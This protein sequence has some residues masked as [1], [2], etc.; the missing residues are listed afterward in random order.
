MITGVCMLSL[1][2]VAVQRQTNTSVG[3]AFKPGL[4]MPSETASLRELLN[5]N[6]TFAGANYS[7]LT[8]FED[9]EVPKKHWL[10]E[11]LAQ[12]ASADLSQLQAVTLIKYED[13]FHAIPHWHGEQTTVVVY[14]SSVN[15][16]GHVQTIFP[17]LGLAVTPVDGSAIAFNNYNADG[18]PDYRTS[19]STT[20]SISAVHGDKYILT[21]SFGAPTYEDEGGAAR[22]PE[23]RENNITYTTSWGRILSRDSDLAQQQSDSKPAALRRH[24]FRGHEPAPSSTLRKLKRNT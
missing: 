23:L 4:L 22:H 1:A 5:N 6:A 9:R 11:R 3:F 15:G 12:F 2:A 21:A 18:S 13:A 20:G 8:L 17:S 10:V 19:H 14:L 7:R 24:S 16:A